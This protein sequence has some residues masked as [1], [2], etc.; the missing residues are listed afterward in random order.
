MSVGSNVITLEVTAE[1]G[2]TVKTYTITVTR[3][4][5][6]S[7]DATPSA[8]AQG[9]T[10]PPTISSIAITSDPDDDG[11]HNL[12]GLFHWWELPDGGVT[13]SYDD[14]IY[15]IGDSVQVTVTFS[16]GV[17]VTGGPQLELDLGGTAKSAEYESFEASTVVFVYTVEEGVSDEDGISISAD[18]LT[19]NGG[20][21]KD[22][23][24]NPANLSHGALPAHSD[25]KVDGVRPTVSSVYPVGDNYNYNYN[26]DDDPLENGDLVWVWVGFSES[27]IALGAP[28]QY[29]TVPQ[30]ELDLQGV[31]KLADF[32]W[33]QPDTCEGDVEEGMRLCVWSATEAGRRGI[34]LVFP[35]T[36]QNGDVDPDGV[37]IAAN[38]VRLNGGTIRDGA[39]ND[40][41]LT[42]AAV[43]VDPDIVVDA[44]APTITSV[45]ITSDPGSDATYGTGDRIEVTVTFSTDVDV[46]GS[47]QLQPGCR[48]SGESGN[49]S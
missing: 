25:H 16:E 41:I 36:I 43:D 3:A 9:G 31:P 11:L 29:D 39:G 17:T 2:N 35:Y 46:E 4:E 32:F 15:R 38:A 7:T 28:S 42:H 27:V 19:L 47:P 18:K 45:S 33:A 5:P 8:Q 49:V 20:S 22:D 14:G 23:V 13:K 48:R 44:S 37:A 21:I 30:V 6:S 40:A 34:R 12:P 10:T 24:E 26:G 1:D